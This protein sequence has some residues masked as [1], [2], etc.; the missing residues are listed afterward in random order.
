MNWETNNS[1]KNNCTCINFHSCHEVP[2]SGHDKQTIRL[3]DLST[4]QKMYH[5]IYLACDCMVEIYDL[6]DFP[7]CICINIDQTAVWQ[8]SLQRQFLGIRLNN[9]GSFRR[10]TFSC[11]MKKLQMFSRLWRVRCC[12]LATCMFVYPSLKTRKQSPT[13]LSRHRFMFGSLVKLAN[14]CLAALTCCWL[15]EKIKE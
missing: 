15:I 13:S 2:I 5:Q 12:S 6:Q 11:V 7:Q 4:S 1:T 9:L 14:F 8:E 10:K 3:Y